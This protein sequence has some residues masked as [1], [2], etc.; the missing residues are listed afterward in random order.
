MKHGAY[1][2]SVIEA[3]DHS[4]MFVLNVF[5]HSPKFTLYNNFFSCTLF[6]NFSSLPSF[7]GRSTP[8]SSG[9]YV[10]VGAEIVSEIPYQP[11]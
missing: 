10:T 8:P 2:Q 7:R 9:I 3:G 6:P 11:G 4:T 5:K 1:P